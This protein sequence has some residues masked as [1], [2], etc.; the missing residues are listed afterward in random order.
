MAF[1]MAAGTATARD[2]AALFNYGN[3]TFRSVEVVRGTG[4]DDIYT[5][6]GFTTSSTNAANYLF[7]FD[8]APFNQFE[9]GAGNDDVTGNGA[10]RV[11]YQNS[12]GAVNVNLGSGATGAQGT[13]TFHGGINQV[14][15]SNFGDTL[16]GTNNNDPLTTELFEGMAGDDVINGMG[17]FDNARYDN[18]NTGGFGVLITR[19]GGSSTVTGVN[20][21]ATAGVGTDT[22]INIEATR[23]TNF[24][25]V[26]NA[27]GFAGFNDFTGMNGNDDITGNGST[28][29]S[30]HI[31]SGGVNIAGTDTLHG[32]INAARGS[33]FA[34]A[35]R[36]R[37]GSDTLNGLGGN[38]A[39]V[40]I[41]TAFG[42]DTIADFIA[43][44]GTDDFLQ[45]DDSV[46]ANFE[47]VMAA[48]TQA[49]NDVLITLNGANSIRLSNV[50][51]G[52]LH[53]ND[54]LFTF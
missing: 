34:D 22:L 49:G 13:D 7:L 43:G 19:N 42:N 53:A 8:V 40:Y 33:T 27:T 51:L 31:S 29:I 35:I 20:A 41:D 32:G 46:F 30:Y 1:D 21:T 12:G 10:T 23:G 52:S 36:G 14:R 5:A 17:G 48:A 15:G 25:D 18:H 45:F 24:N 11:S 28:R 37:N 39:F 54:F 47:A 3:D 38:D 4:A 6:V 50:A 16:T 44:A 26:Y 9:G 2:A